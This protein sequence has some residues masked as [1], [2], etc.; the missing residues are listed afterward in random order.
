MTKEPVLFSW[1]PISFSGNGYKTHEYVTI[2]NEVLPRPSKFTVFLGLFVTVMG[3]G[4]LFNIVH[5]GVSAW[6]MGALWLI[7]AMGL[8]LAV[9]A[10]KPCINGDKAKFHKHGFAMGKNTQD[11]YCLQILEKEVFKSNRSYMC[12][13]LNAVFKDGSRENILNHNERKS[14]ERSAQ[15]IADF[16]QV[17]IKTK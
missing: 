5:S 10:D 13:E 4:L 16:L 12:Y 1:N 7:A 14:L 3:M 6:E 8:V 17:K 9:G 15:E 11:I 2:N